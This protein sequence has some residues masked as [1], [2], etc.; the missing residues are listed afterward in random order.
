MQARALQVYVAQLRSPNWG[1]EFDQKAVAEYD[2]AGVEGDVSANESAP[3]AWPF[4][5]RV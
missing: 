3:P 4:T 1:N 5:L 2:S